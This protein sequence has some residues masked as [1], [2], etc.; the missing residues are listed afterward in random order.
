MSINKD[1]GFLHLKK[2]FLKIYTGSLGF[3]ISIGIIFLIMVFFLFL[4]IYPLSNQY[5]RVYRDLEDLS[6]LLERY[7]LK[8]DLYNEKWIAAKQR[9]GEFYREELEK[10]KS[11]LKGKDDLLEAIFLTENTEKGLTKINDEA[12]WKNEYLKK[13]LTLSAR[14]EASNIT[15][16]EG[17]LPFSEWGSNIPA[18]DTILPAQK[19]FWIL[20]ALV[21]IAIKDTGIVRIEKIVFRDSPFTQDTSFAHLYTVLPITLKVELQA[22]HITVLLHEILKSN[23]PFVIEGVTI[24]STGKT[25]STDLLGENAP[26]GENTK[27]PPNPII[28]VTIDTYVIDYKT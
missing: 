18:W 12:L 20:E 9:E 14:L 3:W 15:L 1:I 7:A 19:R 23:I 13:T 22:D 17:A 4:F 11:F 8:K 16:S 27:Y 21:N 6:V 25:H 5:T 2:N 10:C 28:D 24:F 26:V